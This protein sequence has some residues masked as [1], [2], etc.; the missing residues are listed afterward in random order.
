[1]EFLLLMDQ[2]NTKNKI[3]GPKEHFSIVLL[4]KP[5][6]NIAMMSHYTIYCK[7]K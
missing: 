1:M 6:L 3:K 5:I 7:L 2:S 4:H